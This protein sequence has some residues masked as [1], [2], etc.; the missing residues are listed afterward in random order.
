MGAC[1]ILD[2]DCVTGYTVEDDDSYRVNLLVSLWAADVHF[3]EMET[4]RLRL[5]S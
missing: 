2:D 3:M 1:S 4:V 5:M